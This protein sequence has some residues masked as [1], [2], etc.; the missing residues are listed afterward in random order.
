MTERSSCATKSTERYSTQDTFIDE[1]EGVKPP[2]VPP[3]T[4]LE[5]EDEDEEKS[6]SRCPSDEDISRPNYDNCS[7]D[8]D[9]LYDLKLEA[10]EDFEDTSAEGETVLMYMR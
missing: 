4:Y 9:C 8:S 2:A 3:K 1:D 7:L 6:A 5:E 10:M